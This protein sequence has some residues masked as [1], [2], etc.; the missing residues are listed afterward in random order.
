MTRYITTKS[1]PNQFQFILQYFTITW[2]IAL[3]CD[4]FEVMCDYFALPAVAERIALKGPVGP[5]VLTT[6][7]VTNRRNVYLHPYHFDLSDAAKYGVGGKFPSNVQ[8]RIHFPSIVNRG[9]ESE[10]ESIEIKFPPE[11]HGSGKN[12]PLFKVQFIDGHC[13][14]TMI[15]AVFALL[16]YMVSCPWFQ[17]STSKHH[18]L[19]FGHVYRKIYYII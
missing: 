16:D 19:K 1:D 12:L 6:V 4:Y 9:Y 15:L 8:V 10:R 5:Q 7:P 18:C 14:S 2:G 17:S 3:L 13:K 11:L